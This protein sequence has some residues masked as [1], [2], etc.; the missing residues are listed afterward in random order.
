MN[1]KI[2]K[3]RNLS[4]IMHLSGWQQVKEKALQTEESGGDSTAPSRGSPPAVR[5]A[6]VTIAGANPD[7]AA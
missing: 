3:S 2:S 7:E 4:C 1:A 6:V 5:K